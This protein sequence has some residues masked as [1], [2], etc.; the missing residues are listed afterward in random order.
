VHEVQTPHLSQQKPH[1]PHG[2]DVFRLH[3]AYMREHPD[4][5]REGQPGLDDRRRPARQLFSPPVPELPR[6]G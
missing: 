2:P 1:V 3:A 4:P 5:V 6:N